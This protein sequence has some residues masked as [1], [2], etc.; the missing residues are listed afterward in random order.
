MRRKIKL[1]SIVLSYL[2]FIFIVIFSFNAVIPEPDLKVIKAEVP[3]IEKIEN[4]FTNNENSVYQILKEKK[5]DDDLNTK[6]IINKK[7]ENELIVKKIESLE[8]KD[9][10]NNNTPKKQK[11]KVQF[12]SLKDMKK[13]EKATKKLKERLD[14]DKFNFNLIIKKIEINGEV[15]FRVLSEQ[16]FSFQR[17]KQLCEKLK[18]KMYKCFV[19]KI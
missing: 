19:V 14:N 15:Y 13:S 12:M 8:S 2:T 7:Y 1:I 6:K 11:F 10:N 18:K 3:F 16:S 4:N 17:S 5:I 9:R